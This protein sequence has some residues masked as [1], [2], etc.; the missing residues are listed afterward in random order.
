MQ[1]MCMHACEFVP[2]CYLIQVSM[3]IM[4]ALFKYLGYLPNFSKVL[5]NV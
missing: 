3:T 4:L 2:F 5:K 1:I